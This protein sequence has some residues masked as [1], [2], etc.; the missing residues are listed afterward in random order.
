M[1][2][3][4]NRSVAS[5]MAAVG[6]SASQARHLH[7]PISRPPIEIEYND[8]DTL[9][10]AMRTE[11]RVWGF[12]DLAYVRELAFVRINDNPTV[13]QFRNM[14]VQERREMFWG[15][16]RQDFYMWFTWKVL[17]KPE[18]LYHSGYNY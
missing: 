13:G 7:F 5:R 10:F 3:L 1:Q 16:D 2:R 11:A 18:H 12:D 4:F 8:E 17:G 15:S 6:A 9:E 14:S